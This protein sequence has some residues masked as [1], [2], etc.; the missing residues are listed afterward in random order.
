M[1]FSTAAPHR[2]IEL[3]LVLESRG[4]PVP[5]RALHGYHLMQA[6]APEAVLAP[7]EPESLLDWNA[8][9]LI[10]HIKRETPLQMNRERVAMFVDQYP[11][12]IAREVI[13]VMR[14]NV[15]PILDVLRP[16]FNAAGKEVH[17]AVRQG[18]T[19]GIR[20]D[21]VIALG[22]AAVT[23]WRSLPGHLNV[24]Q[25]TADLRIQ[26]VDALDTE[27]RASTSPLAPTGARP[28]GACFTKDRQWK[29]SANEIEWDRWLRLSADQPVRLMTTDET[30]ANTKRMRE[31]AR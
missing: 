6:V 3:L 26:L 17:N 22:D 25:D 20:G 11:E 31:L 4:L 12:R 28:Y 16:A 10:A 15:D 21:D 7:E 2:L 19:E 24:L 5:A 27:P 13:E 30:A 23:A 18:I 8:D 1:L 29:T 14:A 9:Q